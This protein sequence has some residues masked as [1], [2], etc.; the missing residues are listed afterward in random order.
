M[1]EIGLL[2]GEHAEKRSDGGNGDR[3]INAGNR[4]W[5]RGEESYR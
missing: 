3:G 2:P 4:G 1:D 5:S